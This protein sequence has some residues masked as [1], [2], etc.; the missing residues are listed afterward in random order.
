MVL[1]RSG[2]DSGGILG[3]ADGVESGG[4]LV[5]FWLDLGKDGGGRGLKGVNKQYMRRMRE[6]ML[7]SF[8]LGKQC[9]LSVKKESLR[10]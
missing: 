8:C 3:G 7:P 10:N 5:G 2:V 1:E 9:L 6:R 4:I